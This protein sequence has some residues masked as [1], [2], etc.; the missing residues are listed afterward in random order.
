MQHV[1]KVKLSIF[2]N[3]N[4]ES[5]VAGFSEN[6]LEIVH[7]LMVLMVPVVLLLFWFTTTVHAQIESASYAYYKTGN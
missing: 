4:H 7:Y 6:L 2:V 1:V 3:I 5:S